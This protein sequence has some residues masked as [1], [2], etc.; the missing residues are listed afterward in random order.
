MSM[1]YRL[2]NGRF[3][4]HATLPTKGAVTIEPITIK[5]EYF[6]AVA[7][8]HDEQSAGANTASMIYKIDGPNFV[9]FQEIPT[10]K[11]SYVQSFIMEDGCTGI[12]IANK[13]GKS[14]LYKWTKV[15]VRKTSCCV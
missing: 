7:N 3:V 11:A 5:T 6:L 12:A 1:V 10:T 4:E 13:V 8:S 15:S 2:E 9:P 14:K